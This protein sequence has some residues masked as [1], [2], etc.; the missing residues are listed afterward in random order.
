MPRGIFA[1]HKRAGSV[2]LQRDPAAWLSPTTA[3]DIREFAA[4]EGRTAALRNRTKALRRQR[5][6]TRIASFLGGERAVRGLNERRRALVHFEPELGGI[7][8]RWAVER[9]RSRYD[10]AKERVG[11]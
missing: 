8:L 4:A 3:S 5:A 7:V 6:V 9:T 11:S 10:V 1:A 2:M